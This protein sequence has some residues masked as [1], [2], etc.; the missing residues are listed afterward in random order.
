MARSHRIILRDSR[1]YRYRDYKLARKP[2]TGLDNPLLELFAASGEQQINYE[3]VGHEN[4]LSFSV[5]FRKAGVRSVSLTA[6]HFRHF[7]LRL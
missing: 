5:E 7:Q 2:P 6:E 3:R 4:Q 1:Q